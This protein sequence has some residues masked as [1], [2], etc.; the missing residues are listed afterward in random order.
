MSRTHQGRAVRTAIGLA[1][2]TVLAACGGGDS[3]NNDATNRAPDTTAPSTARKVLLVGVDGATYAQVQSAMARKGMPN[4]ARLAVMPS[5]TGGTPATLTAQAPLPAASWAT[6]LTGSWANRHGIEDDSDLPTDDTATVQAATGP[7]VPTLFERVRA[8][9]ASR[10]LGAAT[11]SALMRPLLAK[12]RA[13]GALDTAVDCNGADRCVADQGLAMVRAGYDVV[14][15]QFGAPAAAA[16]ADGYQAGSYASALSAFDQAL[17]QLLDAVETRKRSNPGEEWLVVVTTPYGLDRTGVPTAVPTLQNRTAFIA[18]N[19]AVDPGNDR[20]GAPVPDSDQTLADTPAEADILPTAL[21]HARIDTSAAARN[22]DGVALQVARGARDI[23]VAAGDYNASLVLS[24]TNP[25]TKADNIT[26]LRDGTQVASL[27]GDATRFTDE[28]FDLP[29][30]LHR[31]N[32]TLVRNGI[33]TSYQAQ[34]NYTRPQ[35]LADTLRNQLAIYYPLDA[36]PPVDAR[37]GSTMAPAVAGIDGGSLVADGFRA[38][39]LRVDSRT[40]SYRLTPAGGDFALSPQFTIGFWLRT[41]CTQGNSVGEPVISNKNY[42]SGANAGIAIGLF[43]S[44]ELRFNIGSG[45]KRDDING[46]RVSANQWAY[47]ALVVD[48]ANKR[49]SGYIIDPLRGMQKVENKAIAST[50]VTKLNGLGSG[51]ALNNDGTFNYVANNAGA[52][53]GAMDFN[54]IAVWKRALTA[55]ELASIDASHKPLSSLNP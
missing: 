43:G 17:G 21:W 39:A 5:H 4:L 55:D 8:A 7:N 28:S 45:G 53:T 25:A 35:P 27:A 29:S 47:V 3:G 37:G 52:L 12:A 33:A 30:G 26:V 50:D 36:L 23:G 49:F 38:G 20:V 10:K 16:A 51:W 19:Q 54:D 48:A 42:T 41:D 22:F 24:W 44:C 9:D 13:G 2:T 40:G 32:Y 34:L 14:L 46:L 15:A 31:F 1:F 6:V 11:T 18:L